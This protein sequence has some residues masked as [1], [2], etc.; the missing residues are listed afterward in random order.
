MNW[1]G[2]KSVIFYGLD[3]TPTEAQEPFHQSAARVIIMGGGER[4]GKSKVAAMEVVGRLGWCYGNARGHPIFL[5]GEKYETCIPEFDYIA[6]ALHQLRKLVGPVEVS[7]PAEG[8]QSCTIKIPNLNITITTLS[9]VKGPSAVRATGRAPALILICEAGLIAYDVFLACRGRLAETRGILIATGTFPDDIGWY[10]QKYEEYQA[11]NEEG[12]ESFA[13][14]SWSNVIIYPGGREDPEI[15]A[16]E[17]AYPALD[18]LRYIGAEPQP[19]ATLVYPEFRYTTHV[20]GTVKFDREHPVWLAVDPGYR[21]AY[22]VIAYQ[23]TEPYVLAVDEVYRWAAEHGPETYGV[24]VIEECMRRPWWD[25]VTD[26]V[27][28]IAGLQHHAAQSQREVWAAKT[29]LSLN[30]RKVSPFAGRQRMRTFLINPASG[31]PLLLL[32]TLC[33]RFA[34]EFGRYK[35]REIVEGR[36][37]SE[38]PIDRDNHAIKATEYL[39]YYLYGPVDHPMSKPRKRRRSPWDKVYGPKRDEEQKGRRYGE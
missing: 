4:A 2:L 30:Y 3:Y 31:E 33:E 20:P 21:G 7:R 29:G 38:E 35:F 12:G 19:A 23:F 25:N 22:A 32:S 28:D 26:G 9:A 5:V 14:P 17:S 37:V 39:L 24:A 6:E 36:P 8:K 1:Q 16:V 15:K 34:R 10:A 27:I 13:I 11:P 18:F